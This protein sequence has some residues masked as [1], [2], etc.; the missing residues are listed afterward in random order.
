MT[1]QSPAWGDKHPRVIKGSWERVISQARPDICAEICAGSAR[2]VEYVPDVSFYSENSHG[3]WTRGGGGAARGDAPFCPTCIEVGD[4]NHSATAVPI[5][6]PYCAPCRTSNAV[7]R[8][9]V[10]DMSFL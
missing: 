6:T 4:A 7:I 2:Q 10:F 5:D 3:P 9:L 1:I 8:H